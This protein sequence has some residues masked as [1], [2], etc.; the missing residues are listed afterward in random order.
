MLFVDN[1]LFRFQVLL[2]K[3]L[4]V[5]KFLCLDNSNNNNKKT[6][7]VNLILIPNCL[8]KLYRV[9]FPQL[10]LLSSSSLS[11]VIIIIVKLFYLF[12]DNLFFDGE[13][14]YNI[15]NHP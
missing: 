1:K 9:Y 5:R 10:L 2:N 15:S 11:S 14:R 12:I 7:I 8:E 3:T 13:G 4:G 6:T